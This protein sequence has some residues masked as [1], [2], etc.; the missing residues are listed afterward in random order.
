[1]QVI[2]SLASMKAAAVLAALLAVAAA[3]VAPNG[4][5]LLQTS[6]DPTLGEWGP[7]FDLPVIPVASVVRPDGKV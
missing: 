7:V 5:Q 1:M 3:E 4:R 2:P 6:V